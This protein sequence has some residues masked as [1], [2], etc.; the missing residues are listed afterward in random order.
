MEVSTY[1]SSSQIWRD[2]LKSTVLSGITPNWFSNG[3]L[4]KTAGICVEIFPVVMLRLSD[5]K[6]LSQWYQPLSIHWDLLRTS[7]IH[8][9][10][11]CRWLGKS[12]CN[13]VN[14]RLPP[15]YVNSFPPNHHC[16]ILHW[17]IYHLAEFMAENLG[18]TFNYMYLLMPSKWASGLLP[19]LESERETYLSVLAKQESRET[20]N[21][22]DKIFKLS[23]FELSF[24]QHCLLRKKTFIIQEHDIPMNRWSNYA[25]VLPWLVGFFRQRTNI[26]GSVLTDTTPGKWCIFQAQTN[27]LGGIES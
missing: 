24:K 17:R 14:N 27:I 3:T 16:R 18:I 21:I 12:R 8:L 5:T 4:L 20:T 22:P 26:C 15:I 19:I 10:Y 25:C 1:L 6:L 23:F 9:N 7:Q 11:F 13:H 2:F